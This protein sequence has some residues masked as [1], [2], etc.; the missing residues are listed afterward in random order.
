[1]RSQFNRR[2]LVPSLQELMAGLDPRACSHVD[3]SSRRLRELATE[4]G[5][6][7]PKLFLD[8]EEHDQY[9]DGDDPT[10]KGERHHEAILGHRFQPHPDDTG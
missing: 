7:P 2:R 3:E 4:A 1:M 9:A 6:W 5:S 10:G 8:R